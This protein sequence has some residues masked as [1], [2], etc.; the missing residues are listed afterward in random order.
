M[1]SL[2]IKADQ[3]TV[4]AGAEGFPYGEKDHGLQKIRLSLGVF[5]ADNVAGWI[6]NNFLGGVVTE[7]LQSNAVKTHMR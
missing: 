5:A 3:L 1:K 6:E 2:L 4:K 7:V